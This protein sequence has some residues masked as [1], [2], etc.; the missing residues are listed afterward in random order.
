MVCTS[1]TAKIETVFIQVPRAAMC[2][3]PYASQRLKPHG[4]WQHDV[5][6]FIAGEWSRLKM[7][8]G[9]SHAR[10]LS[11]WMSAKVHS[12]DFD[13]ERRRH[14]NGVWDYRV[15]AGHRMVRRLEFP[16]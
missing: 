3:E 11:D 5:L 9:D 1:A 16:L 2:F 8:H 12:H 6:N 7:L 4:D 10:R 13:D 14:V 15:L